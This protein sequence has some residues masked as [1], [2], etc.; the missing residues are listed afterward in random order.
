MHQA[1][2]ALKPGDTLE[3]Q[4][5]HE[6]WALLDGKG[7]TVGWLARACAPPAGMRCIAA[8]VA[9]VILREREDSEPEYHERLRRER[10]EVV[11]PDLVFAPGA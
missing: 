9:A 6:H 2:A 10:W 11:V 8:S 5:E 7:D 1:I 4:K 3:L